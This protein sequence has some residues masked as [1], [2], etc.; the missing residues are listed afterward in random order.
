[1]KPK[2]CELLARLLLVLTITLIY[3]LLNYFV[4]IK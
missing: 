4:Y 3:G 1:M 2:H